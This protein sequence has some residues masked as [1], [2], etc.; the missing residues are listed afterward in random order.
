ME[1]TPEALAKTILYASYGVIRASRN[2]PLTP[3]QSRIIERL[4]NNPT[5]KRELEILTRRFSMVPSGVRNTFARGLFLIPEGRG[6]K[7]IFKEELL[8]SKN[9]R[10]PKY[11]YKL[12]LNEYYDVKDIKKSFQNF[13][14]MFYNNNKTVRAISVDDLLR[15]FLGNLYNK[16]GDQEK[17]E[18]AEQLK[19]MKFVKFI[20]DRMIEFI[21]N[22]NME[23][24]SPSLIGKEGEEISVDKMAM[25]QAKKKA[26]FSDEEE[27]K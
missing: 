6:Y 18:M 11:V 3:S 14:V 26:G 13:V 25:D 5:F 8:E 15:K 7:V 27:R 16:T 24:T 12:D 19:N 9:P 4:A 10:K 1:P 17:K 20:S 2:A 23:T 21:R 22:G